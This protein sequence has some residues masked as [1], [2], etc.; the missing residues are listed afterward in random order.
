[1][2][3]ILH[4]Y[5]LDGSGSNLWTQSII[6]TLC[7]AGETV[8]LMCQEPH[9]EKFDYI[10]RAVRYDAQL[11]PEVLL[12]RE[13]PGY[14]GRCIMHKPTL[15]D[16]LPVYVWDRYEEFE[17]SIPMVELDDAAIEDYIG[18]TWR[19]LDKI[20]TEHAITALHV[21]HTVLMRW[22]PARV[23]AK[24]GIPYTIMPHGSAIE[25]AVKKDARMYRW[26][27]GPSTAAGTHL[28][29]R[30]GDPPAGAAR[31]SRA[32]WTSSRSGGSQP[33]RGHR[34]VRAHGSRSAARQPPA[35]RRRSSWAWRG[36]SSP[37]LTRAMRHRLRRCHGAPDLLGQ[38][39]A[40]PGVGLHR[41]AHGHRLRG[42]APRGGLGAGEDPALRGAP[43]R[44]Q[45]DP[46][47]GGRPALASCR[48]SPGHG[49]WWWGTARCGSRWRR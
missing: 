27:P 9:P 10:A 15:G 38:A 24:H 23:G 16:V 6:R 8:H 25:Y 7:R 41:Q 43:D 18:A 1:M 33:R 12:D 39:G 35:H 32:A 31:S 47:R 19:L 42:E 37:E 13:V 20:V 28:R 5:L 17:R 36:A 4:G 14:P 29:H 49:W 21:N 11:E 30:A 2:I 44:E 26:P 45:G 34:P 46:R 3:C 40:G 22:W 48:R